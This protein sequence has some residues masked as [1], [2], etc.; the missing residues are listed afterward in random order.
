MPT[1]KF[2]DGFG[3]DA[4]IT[5]SPG[6]MSKY[7]QNLP[8][9]TM[10]V[11]NLNAIQDMDLT[12]PA[13]KKIQAGLTFSQ[14]IQIG[15]PLQ[16]TV[17]A[18][19]S[20]ALSIFVPA[21]DGASLFDPDLYGDPILVPAAERYVSLALSATLNASAAD[22]P[23][24]LKFGFNTKATVTFSYYNPFVAGTTVGTALA[25]TM[26]NFVIPGDLDD[27]AAMPAGSIATAEGTG[28][29]KFSGSV[30]LLSVTNPLA[31]ASIPAEGKITVSAG[32]AISVGADY[33]HSTDYQVRIQRLAGGSFKMGFYRKRNS[34][35]DLTADANIGI[36]AKL[37]DND[38]FA[39]L[40]KKLKSGRRPE[41]FAS[42]AGGTKQSDPDCPQKRYRS[43]S[44]NRGQPRT[45]P[46]RGVRRDV[47][48]S[49]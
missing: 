46:H 45:F 14:P 28:D 4:T 49:S 6:A 7:F 20:G 11:I 22:S 23:G 13:L 34:Q 29:L 39:A 43:L 27:I 5:P 2:K 41:S 36:S 25:K 8:D 42:A 38:V 40:L 35:F 47:P 26:A 30:N 37:G 3:F 16:L 19:G 18:S 44:G 21:K 24:N 10:A 33:D 15:E 1:F 48:L 17:G 9:I 32:G 31:S 12:N